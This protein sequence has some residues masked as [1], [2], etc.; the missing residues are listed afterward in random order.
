MSYVSQTVSADIAADLARVGDYLEK[1]PPM[2]LGCIVSAL[3]MEKTRLAVCLQ[4]LRGWNVSAYDPH[5]RTWRLTSLRWREELMSRTK[6]QE[7]QPIDDAVERAR[8]YAKARRLA[9]KLLQDG[10][11]RTAEQ[12]SDEIGIAVT[13]TNLH[14]LVLRGEVFTYVKNSS[15]YYTANNLR[16]SETLDSIICGMAAL[17]VGSEPLCAEA[18]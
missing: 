4:I 8:R 16:V 9:V 3:G 17:G 1:T 15:R 18:Y 10:R 14:P 11:D 6:R 5:T 7:A 12:I 13:A 2:P